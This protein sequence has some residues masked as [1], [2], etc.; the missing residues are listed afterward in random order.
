M[1][2]IDNVKNR[3]IVIFDKHFTTWVKLNFVNDTKY[4]KCGTQ[5]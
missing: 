3:Q 2:R 1:V 5:F 4:R